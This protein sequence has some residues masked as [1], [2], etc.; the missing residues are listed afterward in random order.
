LGY[1]RLE[2]IRS[3][4]DNQLYAEGRGPLKVKAILDDTDERTA[5]IQNAV[6]NIRR[7]R[8]TVVDVGH[9]AERLMVKHG[10]SQ[11]EVARELMI[12]PSYISRAL[13]LLALP[14]EIQR[15]IHERKLKREAGYLLAVMDP[16]V[17]GAILSE[18]DQ[19]RL[20]LNSIVDLERRRAELESEMQA[21]ERRRAE[22]R[23][24]REAAGEPEEE[25]EGEGETEAEGQS[26]AKKPKKSKPKAETGKR[27]RPK[28]SRNKPK[29]EGAGQAAKKPRKP[30][31]RGNLEVVAFW[32]RLAE[33]NDV[34]EPVQKLAALVLQFHLGESTE[35]ETI[36]DLVYTVSGEDWSVPTV[37]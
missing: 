11:S 34:P 17:R 31:P 27:G 24:E 15:Q 1:N 29:A 4:N 5:Q 2:A 26:A 19:G 9:I 36:V 13:G 18:A 8:L 22:E 6:E 3:I 12:E 10:M 23:K 21:E 37:G 30:K 28:G 33:R 16:A 35:A 20:N 14:T 32:E 25:A 7:A